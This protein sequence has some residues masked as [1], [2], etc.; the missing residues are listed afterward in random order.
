M[1]FMQS[2]DNF[3]ELHGDRMFAD[4]PAIVSG[5]ATIEGCVC[6]IYS[7]AKRRSIQTIRVFRNY[8]MPKPEGYRKALRMMKLAEKFCP[9]QSLQLS[10]HRELSLELVL[11]KEDKVRQLQEIYLH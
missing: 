11:R 4:D 3:Q 8:G 7:T 6:I 10:I 9:F 2:A 1:L 5:L